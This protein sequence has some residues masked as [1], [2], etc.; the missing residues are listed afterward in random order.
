M[1]N[2]PVLVA[3]FPAYMI[4]EK[5][6][7]ESESHVVFKAG[8]VVALEGKRAYKMYTFGSVES[9]ALKYDKCPTVSYNEAVA[10]GHETHW[11]NANAVSIT[12][13][14]REQK[15][16]EEIKVDDEIM[17]EGVVFV[18]KSAPNNNL[19]LVRV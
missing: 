14:K 6:K 10:R 1:K 18:V 13:E 12:S 16:Y 5:Q 9:Y 7:L 11:L 17:F 19:E 2:I 8:D 4:V 15:I 3:N